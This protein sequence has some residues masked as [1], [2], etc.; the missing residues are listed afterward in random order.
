[1]MMDIIEED[2]V[3]LDLI[4][5]VPSYSNETKIFQDSRP[6]SNCDELMKTSYTFVSKTDIDLDYLNL[7]T[8][9]SEENSNQYDKFDLKHISIGDLETLAKQKVHDEKKQFK[10]DE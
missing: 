3:D 1:M 5:P 9:V 4:K 10:C 8:I 6:K 2:E 7:D